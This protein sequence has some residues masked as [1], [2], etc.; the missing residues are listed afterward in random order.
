MG[1]MILGM[2]RSGTSAVAEVVDR[3]GLDIGPGTPFETGNANARGLYE[4][5]ETVDFND[6]W[7]AKFDSAWWAPP[8]LTD[9]DWRELDLRELAASRRALPYFT[10][11]VRNWYVKDPRLSLLVPLWDRLLLQRSPAVVVVRSPVASAASLRLRSGYHTARSLALWT[12][13]YRAILAALE[14]RATLVVDYD[15]MVT[16]PE[17]TIA[18]LA[19]F[20]AAQGFSLVADPGEAAASIDVRLRRNS[21]QPSGSYEE[22]LVADLAPLHDT[23]AAAHL[24]AAPTELAGY[25][26]P[27][28]VTES[29]DEA[30]EL[31]R[32]R[33]AAEKW[34]EQAEYYRSENTAIQAGGSYR[35]SKAVATIASVFGDRGR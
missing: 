21:E 5:R 33:I 18:A 17:P 11:D 12:E 2:H 30:S 16:D 15:T 8:R 27:Q 14:D 10:G 25:Q 23:L 34:R 31:C 6:E 4:W 32:M 7:L 22:R 19:E 28:W 3:L 29:L 26:P 24:G 35:V 13:Y 1:L 20:A 9:S